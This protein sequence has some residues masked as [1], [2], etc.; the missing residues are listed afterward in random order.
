MGAEPEDHFIMSTI[1]KKRL[2]LSVGTWK[3]DFVRHHRE[4]KV[5]KIVRADEER[6][7][8]DSPGCI[9]LVADA[10]NNPVV[11]RGCW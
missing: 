9:A 1:G 11:R 3:L 6:S 8:C 5:A 7:V 2:M 10:V 4:R